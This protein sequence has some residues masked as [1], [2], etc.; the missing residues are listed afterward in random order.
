MRV[1]R[2]RVLLALLVAL[3]VFGTCG[4]PAHAGWVIEDVYGEENIDSTVSVPGGGRIGQSFTSSGGTVFDV[5]FYLSGYAADGGDMHVELYEHTGTYGTTGVP[6]GTPLAV[7]SSYVVLPVMEGWIEFPM[8]PGVRLTPGNRYVAVL[9]F[10]SDPSYSVFIGIDGSAPTHPGNLSYFD[11]ATWVAS[12]DRDAAFS[13]NSITDTPVH[14]FYRPSTGTHLYTTDPAE[15]ARLSRLLA[16]TYRYE[17]VCY[18]VN[19]L[20]PDNSRELTRFFNKQ[21]GTHLYT[22]DPDEKAYIVSSLSAIYKIDGVA[23]YVSDCSGLAVH[24]FYN[25]ARG[26]HFYSTD[27]A[28]IASVRQNLGRIWQYEGI[29]YYVGQ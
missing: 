20:N 23:Y 24:R 5:M 11:G 9:V 13:I 15:A 6:S 17:G 27:P 21:Q 1:F 18:S 26:V 19:P 8:P 25:P 22:A 10:E 4:A 3:F 12:P 7:S 14:R 16:D 29:A 2:S 28:E